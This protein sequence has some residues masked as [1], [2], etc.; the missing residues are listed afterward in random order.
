MILPSYQKGTYQTQDGA[1]LHYLAIG[2]GEV[3]VA[4][5]PGAGDGL[6]TLNKA[7]LQLA[8]YYRGRAGRC[9][10]LVLSRR[11]PVPEGFGLEQIADD[12]ICLADE[13]GWEPSIWECNS[14]GGPVGQWIA[15]KRPD[16]VRGMVLTSTLHRSNPTTSAVVRHWLSMIEQ[17]RWNDFTWSS[18]EYTFNPT[19]VRRYRLF[20]PLMRLASPPPKDPARIVNVLK[21]LLD[22]DN[23]PILGKIETPV[24][25]TGG[26]G[27]RVV[28]AEIQREMHE[29]I[30]DSRLK[31]YAD[32]GHGNDQENP[33]YARQFNAFARTVFA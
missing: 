9:R 5:I 22:F 31:L 32:Y 4:V 19:T 15:V 29:L 27:D 12:L 10:L 3:P 14:A 16:L 11:Q 23:R 20:K 6:T 26:E 17:G 24:L 18:V 7:A 30:P 25:V 1:V 33:D 28:P 2:R 13:I 8:W 21:P